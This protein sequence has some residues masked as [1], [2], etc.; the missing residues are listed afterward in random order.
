MLVPEL[1]PP[2]SFCLDWG[3]LSRPA[4]AGI[5][6]GARLFAEAL[7]PLLEA[8]LVLAG[9]F[10]VEVA[11][12]ASAAAGCFWARLFAEALLPLLEADLVLAGASSVEVASLA[13]LA[14]AR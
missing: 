11:S 1:G 10:S 6:S 7:L 12:L 8:D 13:S 14:S 5:G 4:S 9:A 2:G 3:L